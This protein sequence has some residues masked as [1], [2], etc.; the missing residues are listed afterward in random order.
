MIKKQVNKNGLVE[1][2]RFLCSIW[3]A[4]F[5]GFFPILSDKF[6]GVNISIDFFFMVSG[7]FFLKSIE[8]YRDQSFWKG[9]GFIFW[10]RIKR[11]IVP[12]IIA[13]LSILYCNIMFE[14]EWSGFNWPFSFLWFFGAQFVFLSVFYLIHKKTT[15]KSTFNIIC[16]AIMFLTMSFCLLNNETA[17][18]V[19]RGPG[20][21]ALGIL[22][23]QVPKIK[24]DLDDKVKANRITIALNAIGFIISAAAFGY[25]AYLPTFAI[26]KLHI[27]ICIIC[28]SLLYFATALPIQSKFLN[29]LGEL[30]T[31]IYLAQCPILLHH[32]HV[33]KDTRD[34]FVFLCICALAMFIINRLVN[35]IKRKKVI[36]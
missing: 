32:Y 25:F 30:S 20:M 26:W 3:V 28:T 34:Q 19:I 18:R 33:S 2:F 11:F 9:A 7:L 14:L 13:A 16:V 1:L 36:N 23:S 24:I 6:D 27:F 29:I 15:K 17:G 8:K 31:F 4:Y 10:G 12:L 35:R 21:I 5:H 22:I